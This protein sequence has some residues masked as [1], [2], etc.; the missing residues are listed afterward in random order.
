MGSTRLVGCKLSWRAQQRYERPVDEDPLTM[1]GVTTAHSL[2][3]GYDW[4][5]AVWQEFG[6][7]GQPIWTMT[8]GLTEPKGNKMRRRIDSGRPLFQAIPRTLRRQLV[9]FSFLRRILSVLAAPVPPCVRA[10]SRRAPPHPR[11]PPRPAHRSHLSLARLSTRVSRVPPARDAPARK[12]GSLQF[13]QWARLLKSVDPRCLSLQAHRSL[14]RFWFTSN[15]QRGSP[16]IVSSSL[17]FAS[18]LA[19]SSGPYALSCE[20]SSARQPPLY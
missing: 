3:S 1:P 16:P 19:P 10:L 11:L 12:I 20:R 17:P 18:Q 14:N 8:S 6:R 5:G 15:V 2:A 7:V 13:S 9:S 4:P